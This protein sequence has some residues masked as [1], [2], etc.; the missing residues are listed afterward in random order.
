MHTY[1]QTRTATNM[2][3]YDL[4]FVHNLF[5]DVCIYIYMYTYMYIHTIG[6][7]LMDLHLDIRTWQ[8]EC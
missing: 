1:L 5:S 2:N 8:Q 6:V 4:F 3:I 7:N